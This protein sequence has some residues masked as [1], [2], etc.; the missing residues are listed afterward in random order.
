MN[1]RFVEIDKKIVAISAI[2]V[3]H[4]PNE[5]G[6]AL[7]QLINDSGFTIS[8]DQHQRLVELLNPDLA[9]LAYA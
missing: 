9:S 1:K 3:V 6:Q 2:V 8:R 5:E 7:L 4:Q